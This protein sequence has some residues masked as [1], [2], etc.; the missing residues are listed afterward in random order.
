MKARRD[1]EGTA[2]RWAIPFMVA[3]GMPF[4]PQPPG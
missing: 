2:G 3:N 1:S 4:H